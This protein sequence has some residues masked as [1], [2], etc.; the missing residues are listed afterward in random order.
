MIVTD[1]RTSD[2]VRPVFLTFDGEVGEGRAFRPHDPECRHGR[3]PARRLRTGSASTSRHGLGA[4]ELKTHALVSRVTLSDGSDAGS[5]PAG[6][7][8]RRALEAARYRRHQDRH[9]DYGQS[10]IVDHRRTRAAA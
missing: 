3:G 9:W 5:T 1:S 8:R 7:L 4:T 2:P 10:G 6:R